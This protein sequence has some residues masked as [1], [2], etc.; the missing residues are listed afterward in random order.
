[1]KKLC[2]KHCGIRYRTVQDVDGFCC[3]GCSQVYDLIRREGLEGFYDASTNALKPVGSR[4]FE[5]RDFSWANDAQHLAQLD[6]GRKALL[7][8]SGMSCVGC[9]WL[10]ERLVK[11]AP[12]VHE[13]K[14]SLTSQ[15]VRI[16]WSDTSFDLKALAERLH[17]FGYDLW[18]RAGSRVRLS[19]MDWRALLCL[20]FTFNA[21]I[22]SV[23]EWGYGD[24]SAW[25]GLLDLLGIAFAG[26]SLLVGG[27]ALCLPLYRGWQLRCLTLDMFPGAV[28][29]LAASYMAIA[30][31]PWSIPIMVSMLLLPEW[32]GWR[33]GM[34]DH[35]KAWPFC[36]V[37]LL[38]LCLGLYLSG[39]IGL[40]WAFSGYALSG[41][42]LGLGYAFFKRQAV[43]LNN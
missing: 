18:P 33:W 28:V 22:L 15:L 39:V 42:L 36:L 16:E 31:D 25:S 24:F 34:I 12:G 14:V 10:V 26:L 17:G 32:V 5:Q 27:S 8:I 7:R 35:L 4:P 41:L 19:L 11:A 9:V 2:C 23:S 43:D 21:L 13:T 3:Q 29:V 20:I 1:M 6:G 38:T 37:V 30:G 40:L